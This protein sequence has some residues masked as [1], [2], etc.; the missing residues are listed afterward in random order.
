VA[1]TVLTLLI[2]TAAMPFMTFTY[3]LRGIDLPTIFF[4]L[5]S[6]FVIVMSA[7]VACLFLSTMRAGIVGRV[8]AVLLQISVVIGAISVAGTLAVGIRFAGMFGVMRGWEFWGPA[9]TSLALILMGMGLLFVLSVAAIA[10]PSSNRTLPVR[11]YMTCLWAATGAL[12]VAWF[13]KSSFDPL[14]LLWGYWQ[15][16][17]LSIA[18]LLAVSERDYQSA[19]VARTIPRNPLLRAGA[20][21]FYRGS[22]GGIVW[23]V[24]LLAATLVVVSQVSDPGS[25][26][27]W[28]SFG[29]S[30]LEMSRMIGLVLYVYCYCMTGFVIARTLLR[31]LNQ[32][33]TWMITAL[34]AAGT[35]ALPTLFFVLTRVGVWRPRERNLWLLG[36]PAMLWDS[37]YLESCLILVGIW[38]VVVTLAALPLV[39]RQI[40]AFRPLRRAAAG[41]APMVAGP[42]MGAASDG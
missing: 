7:I 10:P 32:A 24:L 30:E 41:L 3:L 1:A 11:M 37:Q 40:M 22:A 4:L 14:I 42:A 19:R 28:F 33:F 20:L 16:A 26:G 38:S 18:L 29:R 27:S 8:L 5:A 15:V 6:S 34:L 36:N 31:K 39:V 23:C 2:Y 25:P 12:A 35:I 9:L 21:V 13:D 17:L